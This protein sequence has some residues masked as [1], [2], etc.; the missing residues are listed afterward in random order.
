[1]RTFPRRGDMSVPDVRVHRLLHSFSKDKNRPSK[2]ATSTGGTGRRRRR[3]WLA[4]IAV[5]GTVAATLALGPVA[6]QAVHD[7][8]VFELDG[9][10]VNGP[11]PGDDWDNVCHQVTGSDCSTTSNTNGATAVDWVSE[12]NVNASIFTSGGSKDP[13]DINNWSW[14]D[15]AGGLPAKDN[16]LHSFAARY[17][18]PSSAT[19]PSGTAAR[20]EVLYF[21]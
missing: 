9:N 13:Q 19:C 4:G 8:G 14:K 3:R 11:A 18:L 21:G 7:T 20:C 10:A 1:M 2:T 15:G 16:L 12:P 6:A 5:A 17:S